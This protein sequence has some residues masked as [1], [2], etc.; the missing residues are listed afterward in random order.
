MLRKILATIAGIIA[1]SLSIYLIETL[2]HTLFP[3][4]EGAKPLDMEWIKNNIDL[5]PRGS[6]IAV[7]IAHGVGIAVGMF[8]AGLIA[9]TSIIP[10][11]VV[12]GFMVVATIANWF[13]IPSPTWF[14]IADGISVIAGFLFGKP[15][16]RRHIYGK[17][18]TI[19]S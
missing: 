8:I 16:A 9:K 15:L 13:M 2:G 5:I 4:P 17:I 3:Y 18:E 6:M 11:Y 7:I 12:A 14:Y 10:A 19:R 1:A